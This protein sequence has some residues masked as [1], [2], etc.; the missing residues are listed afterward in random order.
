MEEKII[1][2]MN[3]NHGIITG[4]QLESYN[5]TRVYLSKMCREGKI[6]KIERGIYVTNEYYYD[7]YYIFQLKYSKA[8]FSHNT[9]LYF[10]S[11]TDRT[12]SKMDITVYTNYNS[13]KF[14]N[15]VNVHRVNK[16]VYELGVIE[17]KTPFGSTVK[18]YNK[19]KTICDV[20]KNKSSMD[21]ET[22]NK[23]IRECIKSNDFDANKMFEY[24]KQMR[25]YKKVRDFMEAII[26]Q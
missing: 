10:Y 25:I 12:P 22:R 21:I 1:E 17:I 7:E 16:R 15:E 2:I 11:M 23:A 24:A 14:K 19:E 4:K 8:I 5:I 6:K 9:A 20:I 13:Y 26:W 18:A 3:K